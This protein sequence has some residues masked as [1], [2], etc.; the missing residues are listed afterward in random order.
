MALVSGVT[1]LGIL[2]ILKQIRG[3]SGDE[4]LEPLVSENGQIIDLV[5]QKDYQTGTQLDFL[6]LQLYPI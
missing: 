4:K 1:E 6:V 3:D 2:K 5:R